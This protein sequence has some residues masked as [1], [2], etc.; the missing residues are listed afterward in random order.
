MPATGHYVADVYNARAKTWKTYDDSRVTTATE[1]EVTGLGRQRT[2][3]LL[4]YMH[5]RCLAA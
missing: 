3:Y 5:E 2:A 1:G 4:F